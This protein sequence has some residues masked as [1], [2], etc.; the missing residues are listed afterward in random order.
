MTSARRETILRIFEAALELPQRE[1]NAY[2]RQACTGDSDLESEVVRLLEAD[3]GLGSFL[4]NPVFGILPLQ[5]TLYPKSFLLASGTVIS[6]RFEILR[7]VGQGGMGQ[8]YEALD[9]ELKGRVALKVIR[10]DIS[11]DLRMLSR[12][13]REVQL[14][15]L[16]THP[17]VCRIFDI[18]RHSSAAEDG[19]KIDMAFLTMELLEGE[20]LAGF[21]HRRKRL[22]TDEALPLVLQMTEA[23]NAA[24]AV[25][26]VHRDFKPSNI[27]LVPSKAGL[28]VV[29]TDFGLARAILPDG[30][31]L[32][33]EPVS[34]LT[35]SHGLMGT[36]VYMAPEQ[37]ERA[38]TSVASDI[39]S[40]GLVMYEMVA[41]Q[42]PFA[43]P[44]PF[45]EA[46]KRLK[47]V[48]E[49][50]RTLVPELDPAWDTAI[51]RCL[52][53]QPKDR[54][55]RALH[56][57]ESVT[58]TSH[59]LMSLRVP[60]LRRSWRAPHL[61]VEGIPPRKHFWRR[62][63]AVVAAFVC[64][65]SL[66]G[67]LFRHYQVRRDAK[68]TGGAVVLLTEIQNSTG[69]KRLDDTT[70][71]MRHQL[72][73]SP[74]FNLM[75]VGRIGNV[76]M[77]M[78]K[79]PDTPLDPPTAREIALRSGAPRVI[80]GTISSVGDTY[81]L[82]IVI[83]QPDYDPRHARKQWENHWSWGRATS[84]A[85]E[86]EIPSG[87]LGVIR[88]SSDWIR[89]QIG[90]SANDIA[91]IDAPP[92]DV[93]TGNWEAL[94]E[95][96]QAE[97]FKA[98]G[99]G[100][101]AIVALKNAIAADPHFALAYARLGDV[102]VSLS[103][104]REGY[105]AYQAAMAQQQ[106]RLTRRERDRLEG[107]YASDT[108]DFKAAEAA[109]RDYTVYYP[110][111]YLGWFYR[112]T[113]L[114]MMGRVEEATAT[115]KKAEQVDPTR[116]F[117][118]ATIARFDLILEDFADA[119]KWIQHLRDTSHP[120]DAYLVEGESDFVQGRY[121]EALDDFTKL[122]ASKDSLYRSYA[123]SLL[124]RLF[125]EM[126]QYRSALQSLEQ[127]IAEDLETGDTVHR[128]DKILDR[129]YINF[130]RGQYQ[131]CLQDTKLSLDLDRSLQRSLTAGTLLGQF[132]NEAP[133]IIKAQI[134]AQ[135]LSIEA[136][137]PAG[138]FKP[139]SDI[140]RAHLRGEILVREEKWNAAL[141]EFKK[142][143][144]MEA[145]M[146][147]KEYLARGLLAMAQHASDAGAAAR[148]KENALTAS[149]FFALKPG[150][151]WQ[152]AQNY[153]PGYSS[154][155]MVSTAQLASQLHR[156]DSNMVAVL[157]IYTKR[158][159]HADASVQ[160]RAGLLLHHEQ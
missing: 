66:S 5:S 88:D 80:F 62:P 101:N 151:A 132:A 38:E 143:D 136:K 135:L 99:A 61:P 54:F 157:N 128:A 69:N 49:P 59:I 37:F 103:R 91:R 140:V 93:T 28:R 90:E 21:L 129:A 36:L 81:V 43:D 44:I 104:F 160:D 126:G 14:T 123:Y 39:Y 92:E 25:G 4:E 127:G 74:Y 18:D 24:H 26:V 46:V 113:P 10:P 42:R 102:L 141:E 116:M 33:E 98:A 60:P 130:K 57:A 156:L 96:S 155:R 47:H 133:A 105:V 17:N 77:Q 107:I 64:L 108:E 79:Q 138:D 149:S 148:L 40:L 76:L 27:L 52:E 53:V 19:A 63:M 68:L 83:E 78:T 56:V 8:V 139:F 84:F 110:N 3:E 144:Q 15:R 23:L 147:D 31:I 29:V 75:D 11:S 48:A 117:A 58:K 6:D 115:L 71:L 55:E 30:H 85:S 131:A 82:D 124:A 1:R 106:Q 145:P 150:I 152:W 67:I 122:K 89:S 154:D 72:S 142:A 111:D 97:R 65:V 20:T 22:T 158:H 112:G 73:Q 87:F 134:R 118:P 70:A 94:S 95:F 32:S 51:C 13:R 45:A 153:L 137:L 86:K 114:M 159:E 12:F 41:G 146:K 100:D 121:Q 35:D 50:P 120:E 7:F 34:S 9:L 125:S 109:F 119:S 2:V 16:I